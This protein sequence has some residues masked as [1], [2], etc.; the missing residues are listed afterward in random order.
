LLS[1]YP[2]GVYASFCKKQASAEAQNQ[3]AVEDSPT[4][5]AEKDKKN[6]TKDPVEEAKLKEA[7]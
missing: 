1:T 5:K 3:E 4:R 6:V 7:D 2:E